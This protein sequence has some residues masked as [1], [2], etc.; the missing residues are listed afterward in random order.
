ML[1][2]YYF[3][4]IYVLHTKKIKDIN[5]VKKWQKTKQIRKKNLDKK[6]TSI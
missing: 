3:S 2:I 5:E 6:E 1:N 4:I